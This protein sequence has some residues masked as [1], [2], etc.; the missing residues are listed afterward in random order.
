MAEYRKYSLKENRFKRSFLSGF[1]ICENNLC[2]EDS[3]YHR[4]FVSDSIDGVMEGALWGRFHMDWTLDADMVVTFYAVAA[5]EKKLWQ[6]DRAFD[7]S[8]VLQDPERSIEQKRSL[9]EQLNAKKSVNQKDI[10]LYEQ[11][12]RYL[13]IMIEVY[14]LGNGQLNNIFVDNRGDLFMETF[15]EVYREYGSFFHRYMSMF[16]SLY[17]DFQEKIDNVAE[18]LDVETAPA[19]LLPIFG[20][21][22]GLDVSGDFLPED[23][24]R[25][26]IKE[27][28]ALNR[29]KGTKAALARVC[30]I[31]LNEKVIILEKNVL[32]NNT[33]AEN[34]ELYE[35]LYG[36]G[37][38]D[39][40]L[41]IHTFVPEHQKSQLMFLLNQFKPVRC[42]LIMKYLE[43]AG[44]LDGHIYLDMNAYV[45][46]LQ[47]GVLDERMSLDE[48]ALLKE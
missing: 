14:G 38:F 15:P 27:A 41:L 33:Q 9:M 3:T 5:D 2:C 26:L 43:P 18:F 39:V 12:G 7:L 47:A 28:Y 10:L 23:R 44:E 29:M 45:G 11:E 34:Q 4:L 46:E 32:R 25:I 19:E 37:L 20:Q 21:W 6:G 31:V 35:G 17:M 30:E 8:E 40:T 42:R 1:K 36:D 16:S 13:Y 24:L 22:M 48:N